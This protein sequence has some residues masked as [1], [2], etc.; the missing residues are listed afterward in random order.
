LSAIPN[1][2]PYTGDIKTSSS[3]EDFRILSAFPFSENSQQESGRFN[4]EI[5]FV[6]HI[7]L[8]GR[9]ST[10]LERVVGPSARNVG[11]FFHRF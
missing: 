4:A 6:Q 8:G 11:F 1:Q 5:M 10:I 2:I 7:A 9:R 3:S